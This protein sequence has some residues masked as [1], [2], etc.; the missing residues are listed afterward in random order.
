MTGN[1]LNEL[2]D[3]IVCLVVAELKLKKSGKVQQLRSSVTSLFI[4]NLT[5]TPED[6]QLM[7]KIVDDDD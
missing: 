6:N 5:T 7:T 4:M 3:L 1:F 2:Y